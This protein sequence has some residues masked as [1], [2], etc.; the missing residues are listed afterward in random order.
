VT[1]AFDAFLVEVK[2]HLGGAIALIGNHEN[3]LS[4]FRLELGPDLFH[5]AGG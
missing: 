3:F 5:G 4:D 2:S 1:R